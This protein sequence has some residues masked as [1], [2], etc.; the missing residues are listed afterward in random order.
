MR[1]CQFLIQK[2]V[3]TEVI[4]ERK[5]LMVVGIHRPSVLTIDLKA[6]QY[7]IKEAI[8]YLANQVQLFMVVKA[9]AYGHGLVET[10]K[11]LS[12]QAQLD[13][14]LPFWMRR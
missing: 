5:N 2:L 8:S 7:N 10:A 9:N 13:F 3:M 1:F 14:V 4:L 12:K 6:I 11:P